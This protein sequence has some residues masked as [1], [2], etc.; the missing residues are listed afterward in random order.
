VL[1]AEGSWR[2]IASADV[3][4]RAI[5]RI[6]PG[7]RVPLDGVVTEG[8]SSI[9]QAPVTGES[10]PVDKRVGDA[11]FAGTINQT[12]ELQFEVRRPPPTARSPA[13]SMPSKR[14]KAPAHR[15]R[16]SSTASPP[17]TRRP[18]SFRP[19]PNALTPIPAFSVYV[20]QRRQS[21]ATPVVRV[22]VHDRA[23]ASIPWV[24]LDAKIYTH[25]GRVRCLLSEVG[26]VGSPGQRVPAPP[27][28]RCVLRQHR[29]AASQRAGNQGGWSISHG[30]LNFPTLPQI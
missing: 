17:S 12:G 30:P 8:R 3:L 5:V 7:E 21:D 28:A 27:A 26:P 24:A 16:A 13:S 25:R 19:R 18:S 15:P 4:L 23:R 11:V 22:S 10:L 20:V 9:D 14:R 1:Q 6:R 29:R 2:A